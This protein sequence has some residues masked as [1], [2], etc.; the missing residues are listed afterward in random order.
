MCLCK[1]K[2][3]LFVLLPQDQQEILERLELLVVQE[4]QEDKVHKVYLGPQDSKGPEDSLDHKV[5]Q[6]YQEAQEHQ[7]ILDHPVLEVVLEDQDLRVFQV[8]MGCQD[9]VVY[10][11]RLDR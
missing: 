2:L 3:K 10:R 9:P 8:Q 6:D 11:D 7:E 4:I 1:A 5:P